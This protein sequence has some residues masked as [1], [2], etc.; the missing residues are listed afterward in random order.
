M[1]ISELSVKRPTTTIMVILM[2]IV[3]GF[4]SFTR[5]G[6]DLFPNI[7]VPVA[8]VNTSYPNVGPAEIEELITKR[9]EQSVG[10][11]ENIDSI[12]SIT[13]EGSSIVIVQFDFG[14]D[15]DYS[16]LKMREKVDMVKEYLP[17]GA[18]DPMVMQVDPN[19]QA[20]ME[21]AISGADVA[22]LQEYA[23]SDIKP[24]LERL[25]GVASVDISGGYENYISI[26]LHT[27]RLKGYSLSMDTIAQ[28]LA[29]YNINLPAGKVSKGN[30]ELLVRT[31]GEFSS[32]EEIKNVPI[33]L[34]SGD[35]I[36]L[37]NIADISLKNK[38]VE[39]ISKVNGKAAV[40]LSLQKQSG[41]NTVAVADGI[42][43][44]VNELEK[45]S[46]YNIDIIIDQ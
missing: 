42:R 43:K 1:S 4:V 44:A 38:D 25:K 46:D 8:I 7:E 23:E 13:M 34:K 6:I 27:E 9:I 29:G 36:Y 21:I 14:T 18:S 35:V 17:D 12:Q 15:M 28:T 19:A 16:T 33:M 30:K 22:T 37:K 40:S 3:L 32:V 41:T 31:I 45:T 2:I 5:I 10:T 11:I 24:N 26:K 39:T 20:I